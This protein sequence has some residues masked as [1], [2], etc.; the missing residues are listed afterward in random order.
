ML[1]FHLP[2]FGDFEVEPFAEEGHPKPAEEASME[3]PPSYSFTYNVEYERVIGSSESYPLH[4]CLSN[5]HIVVACRQE[6]IVFDMLDFSVQARLPCSQLVTCMDAE[7][8]NLVVGCATGQI[9]C[10]S[11]QK[12]AV[13]CEIGYFPAGSTLH[14]VKW[15]RYCRLCAV[16]SL[17][18]LVFFDVHHRT[19]MDRKVATTVDN[20]PVYQEQRGRTTD[21]LK[22]MWKNLL[23][24]EEQQ[25]EPPPKHYNNYFTLCHSHYEGF[26][27]A[28]ELLVAVF[29]KQMVVVAVLDR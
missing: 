3:P 2:D 8:D 15:V 19:I 10:W 26:V 27:D 1:T 14:R 22:R 7:G 9:L 20:Y 16:D 25:A 4:L 18:S 13:V 24:K 29:R 17:G 11:I 5:K 21:K 23:Q 12:Q 6:I 28:T